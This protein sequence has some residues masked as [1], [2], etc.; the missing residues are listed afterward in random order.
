[1]IM[2]KKKKNTRLNEGHILLDSKLVI[3]FINKKALT[4]FGLEKKK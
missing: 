2:I 4:N 1:M 3:I